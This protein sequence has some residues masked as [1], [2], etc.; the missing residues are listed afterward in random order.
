MAD[1]GQKGLWASKVDRRAIRGGRMK[2]IMVTAVFLLFASP[3]LAWTDLCKEAE[4]SLYMTSAQAEK[5][6]NDNV[7]GA[8]FD[9]S[10]TVRD[11]RQYGVNKYYAVTVDCGNDILANVATTENHADLSAGTAVRFSGKVVQVRRARY[12]D[13]QRVYQIYELDGGSIR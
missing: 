8:L 7:K 1:N 3:A 2:K 9:G 13:T 10:G 6:Y 11:V 4:Q 12:V 5:F